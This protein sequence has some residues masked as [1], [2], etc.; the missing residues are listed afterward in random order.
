[1]K[2]KQEIIYFA[3]DMLFPEGT[4]PDKKEEFKYFVATQLC[5]KFPNHK[6]EVAERIATDIFWTDD[7]EN[8]ENISDFCH[9]LWDE[10]CSLK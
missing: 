4:S 5:D 7:E 3:H 1:M 6:I 10:F 2:E 9:N 8:R